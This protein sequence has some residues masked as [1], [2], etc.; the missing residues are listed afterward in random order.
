[1]QGFSY[2]CEVFFLRLSTLIATVS[3]IVCYLP[4]DVD[5]VEP[6][7]LWALREPNKLELSVGV[8][9]GKILA[10]CWPI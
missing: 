7:R 5:K 4:K 9:L 6:A 3:A 8:G 10:A 2:F 1:M